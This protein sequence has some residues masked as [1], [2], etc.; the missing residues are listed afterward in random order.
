MRKLF[1]ISI[2]IIVALSLIVGCASEPRR[3]RAITMETEIIV[4]GAGG[5]GFSAALEAKQAGRDVIVIEVNAFTGGNTALAGSAINA[6]N[7]ELQR[8]MTMLPTEREIIERLLN[9]SPHDRHMA[10][11]LNTL[12]TEWNAYNA[13]G[14]THLFD[15]PTLHKIQTYHGGDYKANP[16]LVSILA[17]RSTEAIKWLGSLGGGMDSETH[18]I[19]GALWRRSHRSDQSWGL[20]GA[21]FVFPQEARFKDLGGRIY[22]EHRATSLLTEGGRV[23]GVSGITNNR[24][25]FTIRATRGVIL[26]TG[27]FSSNLEMLQKHNR[28]WPDLGGASSTNISSSVGDGIVMAE[29][30]GASLVD[31]EWIQII[32]GTGWM[33]VSMENYIHVNMRGERYIAEDS[34]RDTIAIAALELPDGYWTISST[35]AIP[36]IREVFASRN[37]FGYQF[38]NEWHIA[39]S[40]EE[41]ARLTRLPLANLVATINTFNAAQAGTT[42]CPL[43]R[44]IFDR[45]FEPPF[46]AGKGSIFVH[47][48]MGGVVIDEYTRVL[49]ADGSPIPGL[50]AAGEVTG[51]IHGANRLGGNAITDVIVFGRIAGASAAARR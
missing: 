3:G 11:W 17:E 13:A 41:L 24:V 23:V 22:T 39:D 40:V 44:N 30:V 10:N 6:P 27:G 19:I 49:R 28:H 1:F 47:H 33:E 45:P 46:V 8:H 36:N 48:T 7:P 31:M 42:P 32:G 20:A 37:F 18:A 16:A 14:H 21:N 51:G 25:P 5:A 15:S 4:V 29:A 35:H 43:G 26:A 2:P 9:L 34:R 12:R 50:Y 38:S